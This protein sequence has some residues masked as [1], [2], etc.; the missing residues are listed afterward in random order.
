MEF[1]KNLK[2]VPRWLIVLIDGLI[3]FHAAFFA[4]FIRF[5]FN[6]ELV[7][8]FEALPAVLVFTGLTLLAMMVTR[9]Y[10]GIVRHTNLN[11]LINMM[12]MLGL[13]HVFL[14][15]LKYANQWYAFADNLLFIPFSVGLIASLLAFPLL[16][17]YRLLIKQLYFY[18]Q[19]LS[20]RERIKKVII[21]GAGEAGILTFHTL[22]GNGGSRWMPVAFVDD[23]PKKEGKLLQGKKIFLGIEGLKKA[24]EKLEVQEVVI[25]INSISPSRKRIIVDAC[26]ELDIPV[27]IIPP[28]KEWFD[29]GLKS[30]DIRDVKI[31]DLL[32]REEIVLEKENVIKDLTGKVVLVTG[33]AGSIGSELCRQ[34]LRCK[35]SM[36]LMVDQAESALYEI[37]QELLTLH[38]GVPRKALL[39]DIRCKKRVIDVFETYNPDVVFHAAA[40]KH[41]PL[42]EAYPKEAIWTNV[43]GTKVL[44]DVSC[45]FQVDKFVMVSTDKAVNPTNVM[46]ASKRAAEM[47]VQSLDRHMSMR[48]Y[49]H[50]TKFITTRFGNVLGSNGSVIPLFKK[51]ILEGGPVKVTH[52]EVTRYFMTIPEACQLVLEAGVMGIGGEIYVFDMGD[53]IKIVD[54]ARKMIQ[55][56]GKRVGQDIQIE[57][58]GLRP[59]E[60]LYEELLNNFELVKPTHHPKIKIAQVMAADYQRMNEDLKAL[61]GF[62]ETGDEM[63]LV[64]QLK[65]MIPEFISHYSRFEA[66]DKPDQILN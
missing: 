9:S 40:Y 12:K 53:P 16:L 66:L 48:D 8:R 49:Q 38:K 59:G 2:V 42:M 17:G 7:D 33:A 19:Y 23:D 13:S 32:S 10:V 52:P 28:A 44:A 14:F 22:S 11:D 65:S 41:V 36:L 5:N 15:T 51:Q 63:E 64:K 27:K 21:Y 47:Y 26:L 55:L 57:F 46:G 35:V 37:E 31:E 54:L 61:K 20:N 3:I 30:N 62:V 6:L 43:L 25:A 29:T 18:T 24:V 45:H 60:K 56:G 39:L 4:F 58:S 1:F 34:L 50:H